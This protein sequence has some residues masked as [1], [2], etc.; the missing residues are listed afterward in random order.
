MLQHIIYKK[1][2]RTHQNTRQNLA[3][4]N[5]SEPKGK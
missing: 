1:S 3:R 4:N 2:L 5:E